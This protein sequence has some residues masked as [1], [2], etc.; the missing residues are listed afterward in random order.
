MMSTV[1]APSPKLATFLM[2]T[3]AI[4]GHLL[5]V[6]ELASG[7]SARGHRVLVHTEPS[8]ASAVKAAGATLLPYR[9]Y[10]NIITRLTQRPTRTAWWLPRI[11]RGIVRFR[12]AL[13]ESAR[14]LADELYPILCEERVEGVV[15]DIFGFG[16]G[17]AAERA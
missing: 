14:E 16:A 15:H 12:E 5:P 6:L 9:R 2:T 4:T 3:P 11:P 1:A 10:T 13:L 7:L 8:A 17:Y